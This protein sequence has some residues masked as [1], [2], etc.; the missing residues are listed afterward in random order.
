MSQI[1]GAGIVITGAASGIGRQL[2]LRLADRGARVVLWDLRR[3]V[4]AVADEVRAARFDP[5]TAI[6][7]VGDP[8]PF[9]GR[10]PTP[11]ADIL[12]NNAGAS[13]GAC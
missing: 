11:G 1:D 7:D 3:G 6:V 9:A 8:R 4:G 2:A 10:R 5:L 12:I 13:A